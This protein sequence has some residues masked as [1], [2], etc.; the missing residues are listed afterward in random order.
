MTSE[1]LV[2][3]RTTSFHYRSVPFLSLTELYTPYL[4][5]GLTLSSFNTLVRYA[6]EKAYLYVSS[7]K[8]NMLNF[9]SDL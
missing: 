1:K 8:L 6:A 4:K 5:A 9:L 3:Q 2:V 7:Q